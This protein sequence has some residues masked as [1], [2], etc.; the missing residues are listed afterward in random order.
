MMR[1]WQRPLRSIHTSSVSLAAPASTPRTSQKWTPNSIR[2]G[3]IARKRG[4]AAMWNDQGARL[5]V[6]VLQLENCQVTANIKTIRKDSSEYHA[7]QLAASDKRAKNTTR[8][9]QG[10]FRKA[11][12]PPKR[13]VREFPVTPDAHVPVGTTLSAI[14]FVPGQYVDVIATSIGKGF[15]GAMK[16][17][18][19]KGL[20]A[21]HGVSV[22]H[23]SAGSTGAHQDPGRVWPGKKMAA[24]MGGQRITTQN[25]HVVRVDT[26]LNLIYV[27]GAVPGVDDAQVMIRDAKKKMT[28]SSM[29]NQAKGL[30]EK[31]L[32]KGVDDLPFPAGTVELAKSLPSIIEAPAYRSSPFVPRE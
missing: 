27:R 23:R 1:F 6:T 16:R 12:V 25:L 22:S 32:P 8:Q 14:H 26:S 2:T 31:V 17:W 10:H 5:P 18:G 30:Y 3:L 28:A 7:V 13:I 15:Q 20:R 11:G 29:H 19:F 4:M 9:M 21:S 24:R